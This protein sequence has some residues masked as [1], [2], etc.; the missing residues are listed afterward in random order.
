MLHR[1]KIIIS[2]SVL[3]LIYLLN[4]SK[5]ITLVRFLGIIA[6]SIYIFEFKLY[7]CYY[8]KLKITLLHD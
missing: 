4:P 6:L 2:D 5:S 8:L 1:H 7:T 3:F